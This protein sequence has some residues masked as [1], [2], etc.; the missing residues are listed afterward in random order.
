MKLILSLVGLVLTLTI[1]LLLHF[2][3]DI[4]RAKKDESV[5]AMEKCQN[6]VLAKIDEERIVIHSNDFASVIDWSQDYSRSNFFYGTLK[7]N[8]LS[9][10]GAIN[11]D[12]DIIFIY[13][14]KDQTLVAIS[15]AINFKF[16]NSGNWSAVILSPKY[17][18]NGVARLVRNGTD[19][20]EVE[21]SL[22]KFI[23][24]KL[25]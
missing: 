10:K 7:G 9:F 6:D 13:S 3:S 25:N 18:P 1:A 14:V 20:G 2:C 16:D 11:S 17:A 22:A 19:L 24:I 5:I 12:R 15:N 23:E 8:F 4:N 21:E